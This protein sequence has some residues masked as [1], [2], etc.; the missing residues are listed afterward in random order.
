M[1]F[2]GYCWQL[3]SVLMK[4]NVFLLLAV[5]LFSAA[6]RAQN[7][8]V[9]HYRYQLELNDGN[10]T[11]FGL[12]EI[13]AVVKSTGAL[14]FD[15]A[16]T[17]EDGK[18][19]KVTKVESGDNKQPCPFSQERNKLILPAIKSSPGD[20]LLFRVHYQGKPKDGLIISKNKFGDRTF[21]ADN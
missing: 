19:M 13:K 16:Q 21:F 11:V 3:N 2:G 12:A 7:I 5:F 17:D 20:T 9:I 1:G 14:Q 15:L 6:L 18:G 4:K 8:D 10:D